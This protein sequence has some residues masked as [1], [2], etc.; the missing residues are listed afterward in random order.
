MA[1]A[2]LVLACAG[3]CCG[4]AGHG[5]A[6]A[7]GRVWRGAT[8]R[9]YQ[10]TGLEGRVRL[11]FTECLGPCSEANVLFVYLHGQPRWFRRVNTPAILAAVLA[12]AR[13]AADAPGLPL[14]E[15][16]REHAFTWTGGGVGPPAGR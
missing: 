13:G 8:R 10:A 6:L 9:A 16:L 11:A 4:R 7:P 3:C 15:A 5:G 14:P 1:D 12:W 2:G